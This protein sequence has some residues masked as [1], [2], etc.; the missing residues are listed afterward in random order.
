MNHRSDQTNQPRR[1]LLAIFLG[2]TTLFATVPTSSVAHGQSSPDF[3]L[4]DFEGGYVA[5][6]YN[7]TPNLGGGGGTAN[8]FGQDLKLHPMF[9]VRVPSGETPDEA[10]KFLYV[11]V[12]DDGADVPIVGNL[13]VFTALTPI[14]PPLH[15]A[16][17]KSL[18]FQTEGFLIPQP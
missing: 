11:I 12:T 13:G 14:I 1:I 3:V 9:I 7:F 8:I 10:D 4:T 18:I 2:L 5:A 16:S 6:I 15:N 17:W